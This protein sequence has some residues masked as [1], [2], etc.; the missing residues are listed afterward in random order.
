[1]MSRGKR[2]PEKIPMAVIISRRFSY[3]PNFATA[4]VGLTFKDALS[5]SAC[6]CNN[7]RHANAA[8][9]GAGDAQ[10]RLC[11]EFLSNRC[12]GG[13][14]VVIKPWQPAEPA[15]GVDFAHARSARIKASDG[16]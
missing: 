2:R 8:G 9:T 5:R 1:M 3:C 14:V 7:G 11:G 4:P 6:V 10:T 12:Y 16:Q 15:L 13:E